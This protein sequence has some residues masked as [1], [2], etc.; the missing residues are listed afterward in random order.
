MKMD[1]KAVLRPALTL[2]IICLIVTAGLAGT[3][4][5]TRDRIA[6][7]EAAAEQA[8]RAEVLPM[9]E[10]FEQLTEDGTVYTGT[11]KNGAAV[12][13]VIVSEASGYGGKLRV[14]CGITADGALNGISVLSHGETV[15]LGANCTKESFRSQFAGKL[16]KN[17]FEVYKAGNTPPA[18][19]G[20]QAMTGATI[21][22]KAVTAA[23][24]SALQVYESIRN[25]GAANG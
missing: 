25:G 8:T 11:D 22:S 14:M 15:G 3:D 5:L 1:W 23:V 17:G 24:N 4:Q 18:E 2:M 12:G 13:Y 7:Q 19:G 20:I 21:S 16:P 9:A 6:A 10:H